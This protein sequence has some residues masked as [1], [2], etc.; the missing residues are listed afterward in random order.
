MQEKYYKIKKLLA[1]TPHLNMAQETEA[2][3]CIRQI[4]CFQVCL[5]LQ[6]WATDSLCEPQLSLLQKW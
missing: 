3:L 4:G 6:Y 5:T 2:L 1:N